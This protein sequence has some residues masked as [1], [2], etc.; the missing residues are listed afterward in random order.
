MT[1]KNIKA[2]VDTGTTLLL[3]PNDVLEAYYSQVKGAKNSKKDQGWI[4]PC[5]A[6]LPDLYIS[7]GNYNALIPGTGIAGDNVD[8]K[9]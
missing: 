7:V 1:K 8:E 5:T 3:V 4:Y 6:T 2:I 9:S